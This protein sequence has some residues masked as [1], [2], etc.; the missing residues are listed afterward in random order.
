MCGVLVAPS[1][2]PAQDPAADGAQKPPAAT[3]EPQKPQPEKSPSPTGAGKPAPTTST[4]E[5]R[6]SEAVSSD[7]EVDFPADL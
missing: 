4:R 7:Q 1:L 3:P 6:P 5:F 2:L